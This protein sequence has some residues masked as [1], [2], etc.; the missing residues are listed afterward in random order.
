MAKRKGER[1]AAVM[2]GSILVDGFHSGESSLL[3]L[4]MIKGIVCACGGVQR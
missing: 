3:N 4:T 1:I 2:K